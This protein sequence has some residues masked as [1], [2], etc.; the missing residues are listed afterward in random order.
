MRGEH[1][2][3]TESRHHSPGSG[4]SL[5]EGESVAIATHFESDVE[6]GCGFESNTYMHFKPTQ[7]DIA[8]N[9]CQ[10]KPATAYRGPDIHL[11]SDKLDIVMDPRSVPYIGS[12]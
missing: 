1:G 5:S 4:E 6:T 2:D 8:T 9:L 12:N 7:Y 10:N 3:E 11:H